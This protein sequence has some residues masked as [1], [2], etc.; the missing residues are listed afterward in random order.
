MF[1]SSLK[2]FSMKRGSVALTEYVPLLTSQSVNVVNSVNSVNLVQPRLIL[3]K[4]NPF[5]WASLDSGHRTK[6][7]QS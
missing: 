4:S 5:L 6:C 2:T 1:Y 7:R 3:S